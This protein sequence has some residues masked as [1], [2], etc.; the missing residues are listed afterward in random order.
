MN[1][2]YSLAGSLLILTGCFLFSGCAAKRPVTGNPPVISAAPRSTGTATDW[3]K[4]KIA[5]LPDFKPA[6]PKRIELSNGMVIFLQEDHELPLV[7][8]VARIRGGSR[9]VPADKT[10]LMEI[11]GETWRTGGTKTQTGDQ[12]D[13]F[14]EIRAAKVETGPGIDSSTISFSCLKEDLGDVFKAFNDLLR[15]PAFR[16]EK[17]DL[18][19]GE[20]FDAISRRNDDVSDIVSRESSKLAYGKGNPYARDPEYATV[21]A[22]TREDLV[23]WYGQYVQPNNIILGVV[24][25]FDSSAMEATLREAFESWPKGPGI[26]EPKIE[27]HPEKPGYYLV[28]KEDVNQSSIDMVDLGTTRDN[29]DYYAINVFNEAFGGGFSS[30]LFRNIRTALGLAYSVGGGIGARYDHQGILRLAMATKSATTIESI[31]ALYQQIDDLNKNPISQ[32]EV[33]RAKDSIL[34]SFVFNLD[35]P[36]KILR[37]RMAY[38]FYGYPQDFLEQFRAGIEKVQPADVA[39]IIPK[40]LHKDQLKIL[41]VGNAAEFDKP[42]SS[43]GPVTNVDITIPP[44]PGA[45]MEEPAAKP[46]GSNSEGKALAAKVVDAMGG[47]AK[48]QSVKSLRSD[49]TL[50]RKTPQGDLPLTIKT[51]IVFPDRMHAEIQAPQGTMTIVVTPT[52]GFM[53]A[54]GMGVRDM[55]PSQKADSMQQIHRDLI[56]IGQHLSDPAF[57]FSS[58]GTY[59]FG[60]A[61]VS[62][63]DISGAG[64][65]IRWSVDAQSGRILGETYEGMGPSGPSHNETSFE[66]WKTVDGLTLP[67]VRKNKENGQDSSTVQFSKIEINPKIDSQ[68]FEKPATEAKATQ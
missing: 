15:Q 41:V 61:Q 25:D 53:S 5:P 62:V 10:G 63:L 29:P 21:A 59:M 60:G 54:A 51:T 47:L 66:D 36:D 33:Q 12:M 39:R 4:I 43:L 26:T 2:R 65:S 32:E 7:D 3:Q 14:L 1:A 55:P 45:K 8:G 24:G 35:T 67:Y 52:A 27:F 20:L 22:V 13:D 46:V 50:T 64:V 17:I 28:S 18:A 48:L 49:F 11:Y 34:N 9:S 58:G 56:F 57:T 68:L 31:Q 30:R 38:E 16:Q 37:E 6:A 40:Y 42:L 19:K 23:G 44:P